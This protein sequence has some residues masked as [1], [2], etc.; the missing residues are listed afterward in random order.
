MSW[1]FVTRD[2]EDMMLGIALL[3]ITAL[4]MLGMALMVCAAIWI[5]CHITKQ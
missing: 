5:Y 1:Q 4:S 2:M 3:I